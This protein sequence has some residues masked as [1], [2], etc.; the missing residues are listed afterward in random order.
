[1]FSSLDQPKSGVTAFGATRRELIVFD[2]R[3]LMVNGV[4]CGMDSSVMQNLVDSRYLDD[5]AGS[6]FGHSPSANTILPCPMK[7]RGTRRNST[8]F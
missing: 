8:R 5:G 3:N 2:A 4:T 1:M 6:V 7:S